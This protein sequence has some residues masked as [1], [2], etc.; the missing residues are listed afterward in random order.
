MAGSEIV[1]ETVTLLGRVTVMDVTALSRVAVAAGIPRGRQDDQPCQERVF[2]RSD[3]E[4]DMGSG[5]QPTGHLAPSLT[6][7]GLQ[8][9]AVET[10]SL[11]VVTVLLATRGAFSVMC[12]TFDR[13]LA[14]ELALHDVAAVA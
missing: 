13:I 12:C 10:T 14:L 9:T 2:P 4:T 7:A 6:T 3:P 8:I 11:T 5:V 1:V